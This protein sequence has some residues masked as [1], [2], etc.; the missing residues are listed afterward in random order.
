MIFN[1]ATATYPEME[2]RHFDLK[3]WLKHMTVPCVEKGRAF[4]AGVF[5]GKLTE[6]L[7]LG[8]TSRENGPQGCWEGDRSSVKTK[9]G[10]ADTSYIFVAPTPNHSPQTVHQTGRAEVG[11]Y[12]IPWQ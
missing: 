11:P 9:D 8:M 5:P 1:K 4:G 12:H 3:W 10:A 7:I 6:C 2:T